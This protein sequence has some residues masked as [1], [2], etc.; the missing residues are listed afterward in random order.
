M[1]RFNLSFW[2]LSLFALSVCAQEPVAAPAAPMPPEVAV[3]SLSTIKNYKTNSK[4]QDTQEEDPSRSKKFSKSFNLDKS[5]KISLS[6]AYGWISVKTWDRNEIKVDIEMIAY[7]KN[8]DEAQKLLDG[9]SID[10]TKN[11][12]L[13]SFKTQ[14]GNR[15]G[16]WGRNTKNGKTIWRR[17]LKTFYTVYMPAY[18][19]LNATQTYGNLMIDD[20][21]GPTSLKVRYG[22]LEA[23]DLRSNNNYISVHYGKADVKQVNIARIDHQYG[24]GLNV[25]SANELDLEAQYTAVRIGSIKNSANIK[26]QYGTGISIGSAGNLTLTAQYTKINIERLF[27]S[28]SGN[29]VYG[30]L[31]VNTIEASSKIFNGSAEYS[32]ITLG[33]SP[34][35]NGNFNVNAKYGDLRSTGRVKFEKSEKQSYSKS[36]TGQIGNGGQNNLNI[37]FTYGD[38]IFK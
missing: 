16:N 14:L 36:Y 20:F 19:A 8:V 26:H 29:V 30:K 5:D 38:V 1:S 17:E 15:S 18:N 34:S 28:Y 11:G 13:V 37:N 35:Y 32:D 7:A 3:T 33:F 23:G 24:G 27:G 9:V 10:A 21:S 2:G 31:Q 12:D 25:V 6:N 4:V 22:N